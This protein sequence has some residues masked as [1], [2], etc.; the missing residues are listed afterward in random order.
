MRYINGDGD[1]RRTAVREDRSI[2]RTGMR[3]LARSSFDC[4][5]RAELG[6]A[7][8]GIIGCSKFFSPPNIKYLIWQSIKIVLEEEH[9]C[10]D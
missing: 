7:P 5:R 10:R 3:T 2:E 1:N 4:F 6:R 8:Q 9:K